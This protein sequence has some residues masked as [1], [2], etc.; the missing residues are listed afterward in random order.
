MF[1]FLNSP[2]RLKRPAYELEMHEIIQSANVLNSTAVSNPCGS[3]S[4]M[5]DMGILSDGL[6]SGIK[7]NTIIYLY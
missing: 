4:N 3:A 7:V 6:L 5:E 2:L 1:L